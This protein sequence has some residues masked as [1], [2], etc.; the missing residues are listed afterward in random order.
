MVHSSPVRSRH[1]T[2][3]VLPPPARGE[4][5]PRLHEADRGTISPPG[6]HSG[7]READRINICP[8][9]SHSDGREADQGNVCI[10][11]GVDEGP[12]RIHPEE[13]DAPVELGSSPSPPTREE[14]ERGP[15]PDPSGLWTGRRAPVAAP[16]AA[17]GLI[18]GFLPSQVRR[19][20][21][22]VRGAGPNLWPFILHGLGFE[23]RDLRFEDTQFLRLLEVAG[24]GG[25]ARPFGRVAGSVWWKKSVRGQHIVAVFL[26]HHCVSRVVPS[27]AYWALWKVPHVFYAPRTWLVDPPRGWES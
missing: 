27:A 24:F 11:T 25:K 16:H 23:V 22:E 10:S 8:L 26:D 2:S 18:R 3:V 1:G 7:S 13:T 21:C 12:G 14:G 4:T 6:S 15:A 9:S 17:T 20:K 19:G 5:V